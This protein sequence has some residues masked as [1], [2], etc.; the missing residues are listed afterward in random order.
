MQHREN[1]WRNLILTIALCTLF[2]LLLFAKLSAL[3]GY[4]ICGGFLM[5]AG[6]AVIL[7]FRD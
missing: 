2:S 3:Q 5:L 4:A 6:Y 7:G 1:R